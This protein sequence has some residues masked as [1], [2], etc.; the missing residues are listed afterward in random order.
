MVFVAMDGQEVC[1]EILTAPDG[2]GWG[3]I[4]PLPPE[5]L[6]KINRN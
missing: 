5:R 4:V 2:V 1:I 3:R 6:R